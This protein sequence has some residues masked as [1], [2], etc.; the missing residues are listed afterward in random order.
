MPCRKKA[1]PEFKEKMDQLSRD[2]PSSFQ[3]FPPDVRRAYLEST[4]TDAI[5]KADWAPVA[6]YL[7]K[8]NLLGLYDLEKAR[9]M[10]Y[11]I[12]D[13]LIACILDKHETANEANMVEAASADLADALKAILKGGPLMEDHGSPVEHVVAV[14]AVTAE[15]ELPV[16]EDAY[17]QVSQ[18]SE[19]PI[20]RAMHHGIGKRVTQRCSDM[21]V[22]MT[23]ASDA[24][25]AAKKCE[26]FFNELS[27]EET[28]AKYLGDTFIADNNDD[29]QSFNSVLSEINDMSLRLA[30]GLQKCQGPTR[31]GAIAAF[32]SSLM[33]LAK[34][35][36]AGFEARLAKMIPS[37]VEDSP[38]DVD[39]AAFLQAYASHDGVAELFGCNA[40]TPGGGNLEDGLHR[41]F[42]QLRDGNILSQELSAA[43]TDISTLRTLVPGLDCFR[44]S[45]QIQP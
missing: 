13:A 8:D 3:A 12:L 1:A 42:Q 19:S 20:L 16:V 38:V 34:K 39:A 15:S 27:Q 6:G 23:A 9:D 24:A 40:G 29:M 41:V 31:D 25:E 33:T 44:S 18:G 22:N 43:L 2:H 17:T 26:R 21:V 7:Q 32:Q 5:S 28:M 36:Q 45:F 14:A 30:S 4:V 11:Q 37:F 35:A 10:G